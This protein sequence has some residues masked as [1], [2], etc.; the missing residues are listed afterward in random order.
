[1]WILLDYEQKMLYIWSAATP[2][3]RKEDAPR[4]T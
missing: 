1:M 2:S 3:H 4:S